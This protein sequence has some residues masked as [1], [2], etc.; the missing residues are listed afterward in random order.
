[1][2]NTFYLFK[3]QFDG[4]RR[5]LCIWL[6]AHKESRGTG[7]RVRRCTPTQTESQSERERVWAHKVNSCFKGQHTTFIYD[8][9]SPF[10]FS[11]PKHT[12]THSYTMYDAV[13]IFFRFIVAVF[14][15]FFIILRTFCVYCMFIYFF[16]YKL[17]VAKLTM[18]HLNDQVC[19]FVCAYG[20]SWV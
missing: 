14:L 17:Y 8:V 20:V 18:I 19:E 13:G 9:P 12:Q 16:L 10:P 5:Q 2:C 3:R 15:I 11:H 7:G 6:C 1:M 4:R